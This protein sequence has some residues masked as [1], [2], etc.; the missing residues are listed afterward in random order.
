MKWRPTNGGVMRFEDLLNFVRDYPHFKQKIEITGEDIK[1]SI[2][3]LRI[4][5]NGFQIIETEEI[6]LVVS[7]PLELNKDHIEIFSIAHDEMKCL[8]K[9]FSEVFV[10]EAKMLQFGWSPLRFKTC[11]QS[12]LREGI[13]WVD[14]Y[15][16]ENFILFLYFLKAA[17]I[18][19]SLMLILVISFFAIV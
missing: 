3:K 18:K 9:S 12:L 13:V 4:L 5:G 16:G 15:Q 17:S 11:I 14:D 10:S 7:V 19:T 1:K 8:G 6:S 2:D